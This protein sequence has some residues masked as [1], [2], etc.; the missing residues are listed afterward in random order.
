MADE[1]GR[2]FVRL[3]LDA[4]EFQDGVRNSTKEL[5]SIERTVKGVGDTL[6]GLK[7]I[8]SVAFT[9]WGISRVI[10]ELSEMA[11]EAGK[12]Q[13]VI[14]GM[15]QAMRSMGR[16]TPELAKGMLNMAK[17]LQEVT[18]FEDDAIIAGQKFL[19]TYRGISNDILPRA[20]K[21]M[22]DLAAMMGGDMAGAANILGKAS[23]G[24]VGILRRA[25]IE[26]SDTKFQAE[27]FAGVLGEVEKKVRG[28]AE[29]IAGTGL[30]AWQKLSNAWKE[31]REEIGAIVLAMSQTLLP[32]LREMISLVKTAAEGFRDL[33]STDVLNTLQKQRQGI[34]DEIHIIEEQRRLQES[35]GG[36]PKLGI[37]IAAG[38]QE[39]LKQLNAQLMLVSRTISGIETPRG[40]KPLVMPEYLT[41]EQ[42]AA[43]KKRIEAINE[44]MNKA[45]MSRADAQEAVDKK[46]ENLDIEQMTREK[47]RLD[48]LEKEM[49]DTRQAKWETEEKLNDRL[50]AATVE[51]L[52]D[53]Q[54]LQKETAEKARKEWEH[55]MERIHDITADTFYDI[56]TGQ[57]KSFGD[58]LSRMKDM[59]LRWLADIAAQ[60]IM[61][62]I[63]LSIVT[64]IAGTLGMTGLASAT[65]ATTRGTGTLSTLGGLGNLSGLTNLIPGMSGISG[66]LS[67]YPMAYSGTSGLYGSTAAGATWGAT[68][69]AAGL[70]GLGYSLIGEMLGLPQSKYSGLTAG[71]G[72]GLGF[73]VGGPI[74]AGVGA[75]AGGLLGSLFGSDKENEFTLSELPYAG[76]WAKGTGL[77]KTTG[78]LGTGDWYGQIGNAFI[79]GRDQVIEAFN[80]QTLTLL[81][82]LPDE[83]S[84]FLETEISKLDFSFA[85]QGR[86]KVSEASTAVQTALESLNA[87][88]WSQINKLISATDIEALTALTTIQTT[89]GT[90]TENLWKSFVQQ[91]STSALAPVQS[92]EAFGKVYGEMRQ[93]AMA[94][95][96]G[97]AQNLL[98]YTSGSYLPFMKAYGETE[99]K[100]IWSSIMGETGSLKAAIFT[101]FEKLSTQ[102]SGLIDAIKEILTKQLEISVNIDGKEVATTIAD[103]FE[104]EYFPTGFPATGGE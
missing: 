68:L 37:D 95:E 85:A 38:S 62:P 56:F 101:P 53:E 100:G 52:R 49:A 87:A 22:V 21:A 61:K 83:F 33:I 13:Q 84:S 26:I 19:M 89:L 64:S 43:E 75:L 6:M 90:E 86:W 70:G 104:R 44:E 50:D 8:A 18:T 11:K 91:M 20:T 30:G 28:Q 81:K 14:A 96:A 88:L 66:A 94:G 79:E 69:G 45:I 32:F 48:D 55:T 23:M 12:E 42:I 93:A 80:T 60:A 71:A 51:R 47:K 40:V 9:G 92:A 54:R 72:A 99:Y 2:L 16:Y 82:Q 25:G 63:I 36:K 17:S 15:E 34:L 1:L 39:R 41:D 3:G 76:E 103:I 7:R 78:R 97:A 27:G 5:K 65:G 24:L 74:G 67:G 29:A 57:I 77:Q 46:L 59:F 31:A 58:F 10:G 35:V 98:S 102:I 73:M 4:K